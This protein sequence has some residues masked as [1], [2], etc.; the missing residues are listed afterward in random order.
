MPRPRKGHKY[1]PELA[2]VLR[3]AQPT[4][5]EIKGEKNVHKRRERRALAISARDEL[6]KMHRDA[7]KRGALAQLDIRVRNFYEA[8]KA[9]N[10]T[11]HRARLPKP[12]G[13]G[14]RPMDQHHR[15]LLVVKVHEEIDR[16]RACQHVSPDA[17]GRQTH[18]SARRLVQIH[19]MATADRR[20]RRGRVKLALTRVAARSGLSYDRLRD[21][22]YVRDL[23]RAMAGEFHR[24]LAVEFHR[25]RCH[26]L[27]FWDV[28]DDS[29]VPN[30][31]VGQ[32][33]IVAAMLVGSPLD[34][35]QKSFAHVALGVAPTTCTIE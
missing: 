4:W 34:L 26:A 8:E 33:S 9:R 10:R 11:H 35:G 16:L 14:G 30:I 19:E 29:I 23:K 13:K 3:D 25:R 20:N 31:F 27:W 28:Q 24:A 2:V 22:Y 6:I 7:E 18:R 32:Q 5:R 17:A 21:I 12:K 1:N 15:L